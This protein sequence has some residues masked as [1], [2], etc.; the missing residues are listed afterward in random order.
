[1]PATRSD[2]DE[3]LLGEDVEVLIVGIGG[4]HERTA[5]DVGRAHEVEDAEADPEERGGGEHRERGRRDVVRAF[6]R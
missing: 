4:S 1:M 5:D 2:A 6:L 3:T